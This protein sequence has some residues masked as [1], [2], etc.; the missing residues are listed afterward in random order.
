MI[1]T[2]TPAARA[3]VARDVL[4]ARL[5]HDVLRLLAR[6][7]RGTAISQ[8]ECEN[9]RQRAPFTLARTRRWVEQD[10]GCGAWR[11]SAAG[12]EFLKRALSG[13]D[14]ADASAA[15]ASG[16]APQSGSDAAPGIDPDESPLAWLRRRRGKDGNPLIAE[17]EFQ[18]GERL[19][20][21]FWFAGMTPR[22]TSRWGE[23]ASDG[24]RRSSPG[25]GVELRD[26][27]V[28][29]QT[30]VRRAL[31]AVG[32]ELSGVLIDVCC[33]LKGIEDAERQAGWPQRAG[34]VVL[35]IALA[36]LARHY[37][38]AA[39]APDKDDSRRVRHWGSTGYRPRIDGGTSDNGQL[40]PDAPVGLD[41]PRA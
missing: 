17:D 20:A 22:V 25:A 29:A 37:G 23:G 5:R 15:V 1:E 3:A 9:E 16:R 31:A 4:E 24:S 27:V 2:D 34:K 6:L 33:H 21:D 28:A 7:A 11:L 40:L 12:R 38:I 14:L 8:P 32:P 39:H 30:R 36:A 13:Q 18:A 41:D 10:A 26:N 19:R 35:R